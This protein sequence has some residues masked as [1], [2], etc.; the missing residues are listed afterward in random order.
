MNE[1]TKTAVEK[2]GRQ[3]AQLRM[4]KLDVHYEDG[5]AILTGRVP[6]GQDDVELLRLDPQH[7]VGEGEVEALEKRVAELQRQ[8]DESRE[9]GEQRDEN[10]KSYSVQLSLTE[11]K[12]R[13]A[14]ARILVL[15]N[16]LGLQQ[17]KAAALA[18]VLEVLRQRVV[19]QGIVR[20]DGKARVL[21][22]AERVTWLCE[23]L[24]KQSSRVKELE[25]AAEKRS[26]GLVGVDGEPL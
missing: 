4:V 13:K 8:L 20:E 12:L 7:L 3:A 16:D 5:G 19:P 6:G 26:S 10:A 23:S 1:A 25:A 9:H 17:A 21:T 2:A 11:G 22:P 24:L 18:E 15:E 14:R